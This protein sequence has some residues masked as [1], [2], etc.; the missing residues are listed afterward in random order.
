MGI[1]QNSP[2]NGPAEKKNP[3][4]CRYA[5]ALPPEEALFALGRPGGK[6][7]LRQQAAVPQSD[8]DRDQTV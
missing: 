5:A 8:E 3:H 6:K 7:R 2:R 1:H 4:A